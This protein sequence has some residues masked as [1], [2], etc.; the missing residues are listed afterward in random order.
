MKKHTLS[1][2]VV[3]AVALTT[4]AIAFGLHMT[5]D[6]KPKE[7]VGEERESDEDDEYVTYV[8][9]FGDGY[10]MYFEY[11][12]GF[13]ELKGMS[14]LGINSREFG[15]GATMINVTHIPPEMNSDPN[16]PHTAEEYLDS[17]CF[18]SEFYD[19]LP[20]ENGDTKGFA[21][22]DAT[23]HEY[24][25]GYTQG[26]QL[27]MGDEYFYIFVQSNKTWPSNIQNVRIVKN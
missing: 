12:D 26:Y 4:V 2:I 1:T 21:Y 16:R 18:D 10:K 13:S 20:Y 3:G 14:M 27:F 25:K 22:W 6:D 11:L 15:M 5:K 9:D 17:M 8:A 7:S 23:K 24:S 19:A